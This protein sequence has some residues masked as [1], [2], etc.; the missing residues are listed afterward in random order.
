MLSSML[1]TVC[2][3]IGPALYRLQVYW[4]GIAVH[5]EPRLN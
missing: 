3:P 5:W 1:Y 4:V 2:T